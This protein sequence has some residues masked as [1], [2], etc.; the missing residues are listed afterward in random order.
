MSIITEHIKIEPSDFIQLMGHAEATTEQPIKGEVVYLK[1][2]GV[3]DMSIK[4]EADRVRIYK[5]TGIKMLT[6]KDLPD[7]Y[8]ARF[9]H[10]YKMATGRGAVVRYI[11]HETDLAN[12]KMINAGDELTEHEFT[13]ITMMI[14]I[15][16]KRLHKINH[17]NDKKKIVKKERDAVEWTGS[18]TFEA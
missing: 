5:I 17:K 13:F 3:N 6:K 1:E 9:P 18:Y 8:L 2:K 14:R 15:A 12:T 11:N 7:E 16:G 10:C 4:I